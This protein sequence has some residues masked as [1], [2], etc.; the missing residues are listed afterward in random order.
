MV[1]LSSR[2]NEEDDVKQH[3]IEESAGALESEE[4]GFKP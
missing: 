1:D 3:D 2:H 4:P